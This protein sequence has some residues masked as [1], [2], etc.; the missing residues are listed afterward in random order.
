MEIVATAFFRYM[1]LILLG[2]S[3]TNT[4]WSAGSAAKGE[5]NT[6]VKI[7]NKTPR[8]PPFGAG[9]TWTI[10]RTNVMANGMNGKVDFKVTIK[11]VNGSKV[12]KESIEP[13]GT[14]I[15]SELR[16]S[17]GMYYPVKDTVGMI[18]I[19]YV[20][21]TPFCPPPG[22][23]QSIVGHGSMNGMQA[24][25]QSTTVKSIHPNYIKVSIP[26][27][28]FKTRKIVTEVKASGP[29]GNPPYTITHYY[30][31]GIGAVKEVFK[32]ADG[33]IQIHELVRFK[34]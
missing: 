8:C 24:G 12:I 3:L 6:G 18:E 11:S 30:A 20:S 15:H 17:K 19:D 22:V 32:F 1:L 10:R 27:G 33:N 28:T 4:S 9:D 25:T 29:H 5:I 21:K 7:G 2:L 26:A 13:G 16:R 23:G 14:I 34:F 31:D